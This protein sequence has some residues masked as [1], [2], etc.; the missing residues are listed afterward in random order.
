MGEAGSCIWGVSGPPAQFCCKHKIA[1]N[2]SLFKKK[3]HIEADGVFFETE[4]K[5]RGGQ[6]GR[7]RKYGWLSS[8]I[9]TRG[10]LF[11]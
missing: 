2:S 11:R 5:H 8:Q 1:F 3:K 7:V 6:E 9:H 10:Y 4:V